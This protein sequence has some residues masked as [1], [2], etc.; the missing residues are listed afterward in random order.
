VF[1][2]HSL[3]DAE[4]IRACDCIDSQPLRMLADRLHDRSATLAAILASYRAMGPYE[5]AELDRLI[6]DAL[7]G[8]D[9]FL[10]HVDN[11]AEDE[12]LSGRLAGL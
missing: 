12:D 11:V 7:P 8:L 6:G 3:T 10:A 1:L 5:P 2:H 9:R 4:I